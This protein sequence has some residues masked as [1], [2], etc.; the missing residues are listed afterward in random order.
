MAFQ[1]RKADV[2][3]TLIGASKV[4]CKGHVAV[5]DS[6][7]GYIIL[8]NSM[9]ARKIQQVVQNEIVNEPGAIRLYLE[10][11]TYIGCTKIQQQGS[12]RSN[13]ELC[14]KRA[15]QQ[16]GRCRHARRVEV[17]PMASVGTAHS[18]PSAQSPETKLQIMPVENE[19]VD[20]S[21]YDEAIE[22][23]RSNVVAIGRVPTKLE[24]EHHVASGHAQ[25]RTWGDA[26][27]RARGIAGRHERR[28][29]G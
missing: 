8:Y 9:L 4:H 5:V 22:A 14:S 25:H 2:H 23:Q 3:K 12:T 19:I 21:I 26:C 18:C 7:G 20:E 13:Q 11:G 17:S 10:N 28:E 29:P 27:M 16:S 15:N 24:V 6:N 1:G